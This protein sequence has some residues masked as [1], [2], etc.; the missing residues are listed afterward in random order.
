[1]KNWT[2]FPRLSTKEKSKENVSPNIEWLKKH[3]YEYAG[4]HVALYEGELIAFGR[5]IKEAD[6]K[7]K[8]KGYKKTLLTYNPAKDEILWGGW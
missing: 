4:N 8:A 7:A 6:T 2:N 3:R 1:M 5:T